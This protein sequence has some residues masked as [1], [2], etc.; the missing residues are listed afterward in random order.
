MGHKAFL[1]TR[2]T[3]WQQV[4]QKHKQLF[5]D[6]LGNPAIATDVSASVAG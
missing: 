2:D 4:A 5:G 1:R 6:I 3:T